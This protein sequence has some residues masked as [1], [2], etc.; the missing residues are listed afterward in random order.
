MRQILANQPLSG[1]VYSAFLKWLP[2]LALFEDGS[3]IFG[4][5]FS[6]LHAVLVVAVDIPNEALNWGPVF[7]E[8]KQLTAFVGV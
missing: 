2:T 4:Q 8:G 5:N 6:Q 7:V 3:N 1:G